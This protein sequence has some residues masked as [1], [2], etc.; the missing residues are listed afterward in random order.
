MRP[1]AVS[2]GMPVY[3]G[4]EYISEAIESILA[5]DFSDFELLIS[6]NASTDSTW[7]IC[8]FYGARDGR[9]RLHRHNS[10]IGPIENFNYVFRHTS[11]PYFMW[12]AHDDVLACSYVAECFGF[13]ERSP[14]YVLCCASNLWLTVTNQVVEPLRPESNENLHS[15][16]IVSRYKRLCANIY[17]PMA[18]Y[19]LMRRG[20]MEGAGLYQPLMGGDWV[21]LLALSTFGKFRQLEK[22]LRY[23]RFGKPAP[24]RENKFLEG[25]M[26]VFYPRMQ[27]PW[28]PHLGTLRALLNTIGRRNVDSFMKME[29]LAFTL[30]KF[31][32]KF[33]WK[34]L[35]VVV[36]RVTSRNVTIHDFLKTIY[37]K[38]NGVR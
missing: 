28:F 11:S 33:L 18:F 29:M 27:V 4:E 7:E 1:A 31:S 36:G 2:I 24:R 13:L 35:I 10:N 6:D 16:D 14:D 20:A 25:D 22:G 15:D 37:L 21:F 38:L 26:A 17:R 32:G 23:Y 34:D 5:Q 3:N 8:Q 12:M 19:G 9:I 30:A